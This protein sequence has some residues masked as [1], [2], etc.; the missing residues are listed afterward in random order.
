MPGYAF[1]VRGVSSAGRAPPL[2]GGGHR[3]DPD[4][5]HHHRWRRVNEPVPSDSP[6]VDCRDALRQAAS[7]S[8][9]PLPTP[10]RR[11]TPVTKGTVRPGSRPAGAGRVGGRQAGGVWCGRSRSSARRRA[12]SADPAGCALTPTDID[13]CVKAGVASRSKRRIGGNRGSNNAHHRSRRSARGR[14]ARVSGRRLCRDVSRPA[15][16]DQPR[17]GRRPDPADRPARRPADTRPAQ[18]V[19]W[20]APTSRS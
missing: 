1:G 18:P 15:E 10:P 3:F 4:T 16:A 9:R 6:A 7:L 11:R 2:Q 8:D 20:D 13:A 14:R 5:L 17:Y 12:V 19:R